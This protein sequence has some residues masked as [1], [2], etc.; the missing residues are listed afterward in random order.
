MIEYLSSYVYF[1]ALLLKSLVL[2]IDM[3]GQLLYNYKRCYYPV[4]VAAGAGL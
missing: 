1:V 3:G 4:P 2:V